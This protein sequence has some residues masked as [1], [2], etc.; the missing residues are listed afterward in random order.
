STARRPRAPPDGRGHRP[1]GRGAHR[2]AEGRRHRRA[3][4]GTCVARAGDY[5]GRRQEETTRMM[6]RLQPVL[7]L[8]LIGLIAFTFSNNRRAIRLRT[9]VWGFGLQ[10]LLALIVLKTT[11]G[12]WVFQE[13]GGRMTDL[14]GY[15]T[16][17]SSLVFGVL[18]DRAAWTDLLT[19][20]IGPSGAQ[21]GVIFAFQILPTIIF[22]AALFAVLY[23]FGVMQVVVR[24][25]AFVMNRVM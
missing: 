20:A 9:V 12:S 22:V 19:K 18:G 2:P 16:A 1:A 21:Y 23:Y 3:S 6:E 14:L 8:I 5:R 25:F 15:T 17:G 24:L 4:A 7:G 11:W 10:F 13:L